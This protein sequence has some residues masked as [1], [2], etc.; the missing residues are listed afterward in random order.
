MTGSLQIKNDKYYM[1]LNST[2]NGKRKQKWLSTGLP[3]KGNKRKAEQM[4]R[5]TLRQHELQNGIVKSDVLFADYIRLWLADAK[6]KVDPVTYQGYEVL[7]NSQILPYFLQSSVRLQDITADILQTYIDEKQTYGRMDGKGGLSPSS[8]RRHKNI[9]NQTLNK[10]VKEKLLLSNPC[11]FLDLPKTERYQ[12]S[13]YSAAQLQRLFEAIRDEPLY[14]LVRITA[15]YGLRRS[16]LLGL[17]W[18]SLDF[19]GNRLTIRHTVS[20]VT[21]PV[22]KDKTKNSSSFRSFPL[23]DEAKKIFLA[24]KEREGQNRRLFKKDYRENDYVFKWDDG[25]LYAP[26]YVSQKFAKLLKKYGLPHIRFHELRHSCASLLLNE[27]FTLKDVQEWMGHADIKMTADI[28]GHLDAARKKGMAD[29][30]S[31]S[32]FGVR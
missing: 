2:E 29:K 28:Y 9:L 31:G 20:Q 30:L 22:E 16:E 3:E 10:A 12:S 32:L 24:A 7:T 14:P 21:K 27:G 5:E 1:V 25:H 6:R 4:L 15:M 26:E 13:Y 17:K 8:I 11:Q 18:D 23:V 19:D